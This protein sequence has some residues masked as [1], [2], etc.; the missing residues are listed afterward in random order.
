MDN[1]DASWLEEEAAKLRAQMVETQIRSR[2]ICDERVLAA[3]SKVPRHLFIPQAESHSSYADHPMPIGSGQTISQPYM[4]AI[5]TELLG[6]RGH[7]K[8]LEIGTGSGYQ[9]AVLKESSQADP[10]NWSMLTWAWQSPGP[11]PGC[12]SASASSLS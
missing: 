10:M 11:W 12:R 7:E 4:V 1:G 9:A 8:V 5:M 3:M 6:L 2:G